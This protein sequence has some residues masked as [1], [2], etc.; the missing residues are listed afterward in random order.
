MWWKSHKNQNTER[1]TFSDIA[2]R[3]KEIELITRRRSSSV[4]SGQYK[5]R[6]KGQGMQF[7]DFRV[8]Q[9]G[10]ETRHIDWRAS[11]KAQET[12]VKTFE[13]ERELNI[14]FAVDVSRSSG[15]GTTGV[16][17]R[18]G[19]ALALAA[20][21]LSAIANNDKVSLVLFSDKV[22]HFVPGKKGKKHVLRILDKLLAHETRSKG[23]NINTALSFCFSTMKHN[24]VVILASDFF[25]PMDKKILAS[26][27]QKHDLICLNL[28][29]RR[30]SDIPDIGLVLLED[31]ETGEKI[32]LDTSAES[33][34][35]KI[36]EEQS[37]HEK[38]VRSVIKQSGAS[39]L[40]LVTGADP[41]KKLREFF[42]SRRGPRR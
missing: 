14:V 42:L 31:P 4:L 36:R 21:G 1:T 17:K 32:L 35:K 2:K 18:E 37:L 30:D 27:A 13:E 19:M 25:A 20:I 28:L 39:Y 26:L 8:Y 40:P 34:R 29:D 12:Y 23:S 24:S 5:S 9:Y 38:R 6:F 16:S 11:A 15:F 10:D 33:V 22:E 7:A 3:V 41:V